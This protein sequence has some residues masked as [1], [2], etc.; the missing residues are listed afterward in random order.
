M[1]IFIYISNI[2]PP[3]W[4]FGNIKHWAIYNSVERI[5]DIAVS[6]CQNVI[7]W[8][9]QNLVDW[10]SRGEG[11][12]YISNGFMSFHGFLRSKVADFHQQFFSYMNG[13]FSSLQH[14]L[15]AEN[16]KSGK[17]SNMTGEE[18]ER[19]LLTLVKL[20]PP[21]SQELE[22]N[23]IDFFLFLFDFWKCS[24]FPTSTNISIC[25]DRLYTKLTLNLFT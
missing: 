6:G 5:F 8:H 20:E 3:P 4:F 23:K 9:S 7:K 17:M 1:N 25:T 13:V 14:I 10:I 12:I 22:L 21:A 2:I 19:M 16:E 11:P 15:L 18:R 24:S